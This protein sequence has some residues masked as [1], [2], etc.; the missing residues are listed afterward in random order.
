MVRILFLYY[1]QIGE[2]QTDVIIL[3]GYKNMNESKHLPGQRYD[4]HS[5]QNWLKFLALS[6]EIEVLPPPLIIE[7]LDNLCHV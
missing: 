3:P 5:S 6:S 1:F 2:H 7:D 4:F